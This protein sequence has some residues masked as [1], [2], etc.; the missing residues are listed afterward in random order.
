MIY[1][2]TNAFGLALVPLHKEYLKLESEF[3]ESCNDQE[4]LILSDKELL[5]PH[6]PGLAKEFG[7]KK[8]RA[9]EN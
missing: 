6:S 8:T 9:G 3:A 7:R 2:A 5:K 4:S 1:G